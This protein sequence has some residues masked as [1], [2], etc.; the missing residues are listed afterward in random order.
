MVMRG[1]WSDNTGGIPV[2]GA[3]ACT[4]VRSPLPHARPDPRRSSPATHRPTHADTSPHPSA[5]T[6]RPVPWIVLVGKRPAKNFRTRA[7]GSNPPA[8]LQYCVSLTDPQPE[9]PPAPKPKRH[10]EPMTPEREDVF[11]DALIKSGGSFAYASMAAAPKN[12]NGNPRSGKNNA[13]PC[14]ETWRSY[15]KRSPEFAIRVQNALTSALANMENLL[16]ERAHQKDTRPIV[17]RD[18]NVV[19]VAEDSRNANSMLLAWL[20]KHSPE[21]LEKKIVALNAEVLH[22]NADD[23]SA[24]GLRYVVRAEHVRMLEPEKQKLLMELLTDIEEIR[25]AEKKQ[26]QLPDQTGGEFQ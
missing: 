5:L 23:E 22:K 17:D 14:Y 15:I 2:H 13:A 26:K 20:R 6:A 9:T 16:H 18:G 19:A 3:S 4:P 10:V 11:I 25:L 12:G 24:G 8:P 21:W 7:H 1:F